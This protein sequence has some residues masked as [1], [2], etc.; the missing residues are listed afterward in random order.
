MLSQK[1]QIENKE[2]NRLTGIIEWPADGIVRTYA[3]FAHC[4]TCGKNSHAAKRISRRLAS[5]GIA[6]VRFDFAGIG[7][8]EGDFA[9]TNFTSNIEDLIS[10]INYLVEEEMVPQLLIGHSL[11][12]AAALA[13]ASQCDEIRAI[14]TIG[15]PARPTHLKNLLPDNL[16]KMDRDEAVEVKLGYKTI[17]IKKQ[18]LDDLE[19]QNTEKALFSLNRPALI[20]HSPVDSIVEIENAE[21]IF[22][23]LHH[24]KSFLSLGDMNHLITDEKDANYI[25]NV[26]YEWVQPYIDLKVMEEDEEKD[27]FVTAVLDNDHFTTEIRTGKHALVADE[28]KSYGGKDLGPS[29]YQYVSAGLAACTAM[30]LRMY[31]KRKDWDLGEI[32]VKVD[33]DKKHCKDCHDE[34]SKI[35]HFL[36]TISI[37]NDLTEKQQEKILEIANKCPVHRSLMSKNEIP[38]DLAGGK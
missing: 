6:V 37:E 4:Y 9:D 1:V 36:R 21:M 3:I 27:P 29:P 35:D 23:A 16:D 26:I 25:G 5:K 17:R 20:A 13:A 30:T 14:V 24:P 34:N 12:G 18:L 32:K 7:E 10:F 28:P 33:H 31:S 11:G 2:G 19:D 22:K 15:A 8:S 38:T